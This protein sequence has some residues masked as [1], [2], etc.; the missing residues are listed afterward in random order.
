MIPLAVF[1]NYLG[2]H[3]KEKYKVCENLK[4]KW[5]GKISRAQTKNNIKMYCLLHVDRKLTIHSGS[6]VQQRDSLQL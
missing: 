2:N 5:K 3:M 6:R 4:K 1:T